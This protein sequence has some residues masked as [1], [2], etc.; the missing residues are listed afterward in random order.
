MLLEYIAEYKQSSP[1]VGLKD[2]FDKPVEGI[3][4]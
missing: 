2:L 1:L 4:S 3:F